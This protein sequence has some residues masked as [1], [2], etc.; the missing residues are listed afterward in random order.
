MGGVKRR[1]IFSKKLFRNFV[2]LTYINHICNIVFI[3]KSYIS[4]LVFVDFEIL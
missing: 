2:L 1:I 3:L 4:F